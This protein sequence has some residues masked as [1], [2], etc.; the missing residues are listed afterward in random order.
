MD[1][2]Q[3]RGQMKRDCSNTEIRVN[4][5]NENRDATERQ[6][7]NTPDETRSIKVEVLGRHITPNGRVPPVKA[8]KKTG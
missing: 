1:N 2:A 4:R 5:T 7:R 8:G 3:P 6:L